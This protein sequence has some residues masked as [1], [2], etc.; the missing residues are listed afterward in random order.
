MRL[1]AD[2]YLI[3]LQSSVPLLPPC[4]TVV[5]A[6]CVIKAA[7][8]TST[9]PH[10]LRPKAK[11][12]QWG[13]IYGGGFHVFEGEQHSSNRQPLVLPF[14]VLLPFRVS[15]TADGRSFVGFFSSPVSRSHP[16]E[17]I[18][19]DVVF[20]F[21]LFISVLYFFLFLNILVSLFRFYGIFLA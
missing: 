6:S 1:I 19:V 21:L 8:R 14:V 11:A 16:E 2:S 9:A 7:V 15:F 20:T 5:A 4:C 3:C 17:D 10:D 18:S 12:K 13:K